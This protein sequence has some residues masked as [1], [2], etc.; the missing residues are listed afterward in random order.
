MMH[1]YVLLTI[2]H[3]APLFFLSIRSSFSAQGFCS[4]CARARDP[5]AVFV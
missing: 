2:H 1:H 3:H 5:H 4:L